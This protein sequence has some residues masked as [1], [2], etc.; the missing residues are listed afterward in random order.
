M[1]VD[2]SELI[3]G[4]RGCGLTGKVDIGEYGSDTALPDDNFRGLEN[5]EPALELL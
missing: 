2:V 4:E 3:E 5:V 1:P